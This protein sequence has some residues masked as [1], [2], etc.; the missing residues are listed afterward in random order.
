MYE[1]LI[2]EIKNADRILIGIG[3]QASVENTFS[4]DNVM[5]YDDASQ[6]IERVNQKYDV[7]LKFYNK[8]AQ[9]LSGKDYFVITTNYDGIIK[10]S[11]LNKIKIVAPCG[12]IKKLQCEC[13]EL[14]DIPEGYY[15]R[16][17][18][19]VCPK[20][21]AKFT[22]NVFNRQKYN[23]NGY[24]KQWNM[25]NMWLTGTLGKKLLILELGC[26]FSLLSI[27]RVPF[28]RIAMINQKAV[29]YRVSDKYPQKT[30]ELSDKMISV[31]MSPLEFISQITL[32]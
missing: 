8:L 27:I 13:E 24:L 30:A 25:Y 20:C 9:I 2:D 4:Y 16:N 6:Y 31:E 32:L 10:E 15:E 17:E 7:I 22:S 23:E 12:S 3:A 29:Y 5:S 19:L 1:K 28:E 26:D 14:I 11:D 21:N 18:H